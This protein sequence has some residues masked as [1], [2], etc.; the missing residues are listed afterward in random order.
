MLKNLPFKP[1][2]SAVII[3]SLFAIATPASAGTTVKGITIDG[4]YKETLSGDDLL[5]VGTDTST[6][7]VKP[8]GSTP[9]KTSNNASLVMKGA[10]ITLNGENSL[11]AIFVNT[12]GNVFVGNDKTDSLSISALSSAVSNTSG[13]VVLDAKDL[14]LSTKRINKTGNEVG[15]IEMRGT[16]ATGDAK[17]VIGEHARTIS[18]ATNQANTTR[19][20]SGSAVRVL[21][22][23]TLTL[24]GSE[25]ENVTLSANHKGA[26]FGIRAESP[27]TP[28][29][30]TIRGKNITINAVGDQTSTGVFANVNSSVAIGDADQSTINISSTNSV[31][32]G[33]E[34]YSYGVWVSN[35]AEYEKAGGSLKLSGK[36]VNIHSEGVG[37]VYGALVA[38]NDLSPVKK[39]ALTI[40]ADTITI[41]AVS[42]NETT[43][44]SG[45]VAMSAGDV[46]VAGNTVISAD[47][48]LV[49]RGDASIVI[50]K[51]G[52]H[53]TQMNGDI[54]FNYDG[55]TSGTAVN[56]N[57]DV[58]LAG[59]NSFWN[60]ST[61][62]SWNGLPADGADSSKLTVSDMK[63]TVKDG[64]Q[65]TPTAIASTEPTAQTGQKA[66]A[67]NNLVLDNGIV[68]VKDETV[69]V[70]VEQMSGSGTVR[71]AT[72]LTAEEGWQAGTF[73]VD[74]AAADSSLTVNLANEDL[75][76]DLT[77]DDVTSD[78]A[79][80]L[81]G[82]VA[83]E[84]VETIM[85]VDEGMYN[86]GFIIDVE[87]NVHST[88][89]NSVMQSTLELATVAP[90]ALNRILTND[91]HK[92]MG[93]IRSM[94]QTSGAW[95]R[96]D[97][98]RLSAESG[99]ENDF[100]TIQ[101][102]VDTVPTAGAPR[103]GVAFSY[104]MSDVDYRRGEAD[105]D[106]YSLAAY[107]LWMGENGQFADI[108]A[109]LGTA[110]TDMTIDGNKKGSMDN[111]VTALS[112][113]FGWRFDLSKSFYL[114]PQVELAYTHV[115][116]DDLS[117]SDGSTYRFDDADS[118]MGRAGF[119]FGMRCPENGNTAYLRV[120]AV[121]EFLGDNAVTGGNGK[122]YEID[123]KDTWVE[124]GLGANFNLTD[125][126]YVW[127]D[128]ERTSGGY[129]DEDWRATVGVRY[130]F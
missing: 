61:L 32:T 63:L 80:Q 73:T 11:T 76:K 83:A 42:K 9:I 15:A 28:S 16:E 130:A 56:A 58:T 21:Y 85:K 60:G 34:A 95:A 5:E 72:D 87:A 55:P 86:E 101:V 107:G 4:E 91:V 40:E 41:K 30:V 44:S 100:H 108:V 33:K 114:E 69:Q 82:N 121:H 92:R 129:L 59:A 22:G 126:T 36:S 12:S 17:T 128:V 71:L 119:A 89:P 51:D 57:I 120:S 93:D 37:S 111:I 50:N 117:L 70:K 109:R 125:S 88:G 6:I 39:S 123:G 47:S 8:G 102:G 38:S 19:V 94:N 99:L 122:V 74:S 106:V 103:F 84:G 75:T 112:G 96:Y 66:A 29:N 54:E 64:A 13:T 113:E 90:L 14:A 20:L 97:G 79:K 77:S 62:V 115:D 7:V 46:K 116:A 52:K 67:L 27:Y 104:T 18:I 23:G 35:V 81:L 127:A 105:M 25:T 98:G 1:L 31:T 48:A 68:N 53:W 43:S 10:D 24:G 49:A 124:Y 3:T 26:T 65:W 118:L 2:M 45:I 78:Q 110:K